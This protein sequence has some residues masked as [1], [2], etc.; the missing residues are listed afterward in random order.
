[1]TDSY[2]TDRIKVLYSTFI[3]GLIKSGNSFLS[4]SESHQLHF[5][6][7]KC[8]NTFYAFSIFCFVTRAVAG[9]ETRKKWK[10]WKD[11]LIGD[12]FLFIFSFLCFVVFII[13]YFSHFVKH[14]YKLFSKTFHTR[15]VIPI[16]A[17]IQTRVLFLP[18]LTSDYITINIITYCLYIKYHLIAISIFS[19]N[20]NYR[21]RY[22]E[23]TFFPP[24]IPRGWVK[25]HN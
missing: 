11:L 8:G 2:E 3:Y 23:Q 16:P 6:R 18:Q 22:I 21:K 4:L 12:A 7:R 19:Y 17:H 9:V 15:C 13:S 20:H 10:Y 1:M 5:W 24:F 14:K 25:T